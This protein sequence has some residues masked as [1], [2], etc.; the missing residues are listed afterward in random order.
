MGIYDGIKGLF[1]HL[2]KFQGW[3]RLYAYRDGLSTFIDRQ[4]QYLVLF[5]KALLIPSQNL[6]TNFVLLL[7]HKKGAKDHVILVTLKQER[8]K[9]LKDF[10]DQF[11]SE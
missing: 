4:S 8:V 7:D 6:G 10:F 5:P 2:E 3:N 9:F 1:E 11:N